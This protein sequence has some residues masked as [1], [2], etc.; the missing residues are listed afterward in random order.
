MAKETLA[1]ALKLLFGEGNRFYRMLLERAIEIAPYA[2]PESAPRL[3]LKTVIIDRLYQAG[4]LEV[5]KA[6]LDASDLY[7]QERWNART[8]VYATDPVAIAFI[9]A[10]GADPDEILAE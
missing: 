3:V 9:T 4:K 1:V 5:A 10:I 8:A 2:P 6:A 7:T